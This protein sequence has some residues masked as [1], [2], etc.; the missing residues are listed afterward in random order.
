MST[1][2][3]I[4]I[5]NLG[6]RIVYLGEASLEEVENQARAEAKKCKSVCNPARD[7]D[8]V[9]R[10]RTKIIAQREY[11][12]RYVR[13]AE[14]QWQHEAAINAAREGIEN[15]YAVYSDREIAMKHYSIDD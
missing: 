4:A 14:N 13:V 11:I 3:K 10:E 12:G 8:E 15:T 5:G 7:S 6:V 9:I 2:S 1:F